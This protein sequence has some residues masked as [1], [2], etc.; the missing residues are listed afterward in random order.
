MFG[1]HR[2]SALGA[3]SPQTYQQMGRGGFVEQ[4]RTSPFPLA[5]LEDADEVPR[6]GRV[7]RQRARPLQRTTRPPHAPPHEQLR[8]LVEEAEARVCRGAAASA[9][10]SPA[11]ATPAGAPAAPAGSWG[12]KGLVEADGGCGAHGAFGA[13]R[14][15][16]QGERRGLT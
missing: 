14:W 3:S 12:E 7:Q 15:E 13:L 6:V 11:T 2:A 1:R 10:S 5:N 16:A 4:R 9:T 8:A